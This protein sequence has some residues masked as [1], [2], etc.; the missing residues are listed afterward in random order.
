L[1][2]RPVGDALS[3][4]KT[5]AAND[6]GTIVNPIHKLGGKA[7]LP[8][9]RLTDHRHQPTATLLDR[10]LELPLK[11]VELLLATD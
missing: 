7:G 1:C 10:S 8:H 2:D 9:S 3:I 11:L 5:S 6:P 4:G